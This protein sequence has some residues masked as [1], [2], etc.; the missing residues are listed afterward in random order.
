MKPSPHER[1][2]ERLHTLPW[3]AVLDI[4]PQVSAALGPMLEGMPAEK[5]L[6]RLLR[7]LPDLTALQRKAVA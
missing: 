6:D 7:A 2:L 1:A 5:T 4:I 3:A